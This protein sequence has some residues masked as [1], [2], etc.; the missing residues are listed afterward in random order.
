VASPQSSYDP[1][2]PTPYEAQP[3]PPQPPPPEPA[4][5]TPS[6]LGEQQGGFQFPGHGNISHTGAVAGLLDNVMR[7]YVQGKSIGAAK[8]ALQLK[9]KSDDLNA[10]YTADAERLW[11]ISQ[12]QIAEKGTVD[13]NSDE[14][15]QAYSAVQGSWGALQDF[16]GTIIQQQGGKKGKKQEERTPAEVLSDPKSTPQE[17]AA[18]L[19]GVSQK[20]GPPI[21]GQIQSYAAQAQAKAQR[22]EVQDAD[23]R[24]KANLELSQLRTQKEP[25]T[26]AQQARAKQLEEYLTPPIKETG[27]TRLYESPDKS[28]RKWLVPGQEPKDWNAVESS[29]QAGGRP[30]RAF[31]IAAN[32]KPTSVLLDPETNQEKPGSENPEIVPPSGMLEHISNGFYMYTDNEG[33][34]HKVP[35]SRTSGVALPKPTASAAGG[36]QPGAAPTG[37]GGGP[38]ATAPHN[39]PPT[40]P[41]VNSAAGHKTDSNGDVI[42]HK[43]PIARAKIDQLDKETSEQYQKAIDKFNSDMNDIAGVKG[44]TPQAMDELR[45]KRYQRL[46]EE[47]NAIG[48]EHSQ[49]MRDMGLI[50]AEDSGKQ[51]GSAAPS[52]SKGT[53]KKSAFLKENPGATDA[54][55]EAI[56]PQL[57]AQHY[58]TVDN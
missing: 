51:G 49:R 9:K 56:K 13:Q 58:D 27:T 29:A 37:A 40:P 57:K 6:P 43:G 36:G 28:E 38:A 11:T 48:A 16:R 18:A 54:D 12:K 39:T 45:K 55:W 33:N 50:P 24:A 31:K 35:M 53:V 14:F 19:H 25:L 22:P 44:I 2:S 10:S 30:I 47:N 26:E 15:K 52:Q 42:G 3:L 20:L 7:G 4:Q 1:L 5:P 23:I 8:Q 21:F 34:V 46:Q 41:K 17:K 32:G